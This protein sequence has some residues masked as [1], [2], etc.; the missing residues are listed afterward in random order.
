MLDNRYFC[1]GHLT[2]EAFSA[3]DREELS[4]D[5]RYLF[6][7]HLENCRS[8]MDDYTD[9]L[10]DE[11]L[12]SPPEGLQNRI[13]GEI[14]KEYTTRRRSKTIALQVGKLAVAVCLTMVFFLGGVFEFINST[15]K[16]D[17][18][19]AAPPSSEQMRKKPKEVKPRDNKLAEIA[20]GFNAGFSKFAELFQTDFRFGGDVTHESK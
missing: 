5:E 15:G 4:V 10:T 19:V 3:L 17:P 11:S 9:Y 7:S 1:D 12:L 20:S 6:L 2:A 13:A 16:V 14:K 18:Q 8:C